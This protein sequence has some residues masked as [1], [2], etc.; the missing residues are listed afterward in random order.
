MSYVQQIVH[1]L[2]CAAT[3]CP[4]TNYVGLMSDSCLR[5]YNRYT[6]H[7]TGDETIRQPPNVTG[8]TGGQRY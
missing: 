5:T 7:G 3:D 4:V 8:H 2:V 1:T 6:A